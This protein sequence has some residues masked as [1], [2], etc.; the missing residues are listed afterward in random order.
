MTA[1]TTIASAQQA[2]LKLHSAQAAR[3]E[4]VAWRHIANDDPP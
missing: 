3:F 1:G 4:T 2:E